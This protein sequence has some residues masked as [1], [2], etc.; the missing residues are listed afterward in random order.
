MLDT[1]APLT[2]LLQTQCSANFKW[3]AHPTAL[4]HW[5][6]FPLFVFKA[7]FSSSA[8]QVS[9]LSSPH[10]RAGEGTSC[11][12]E[13]LPLAIT[14]RATSQ[15]QAGRGSQRKDLASLHWTS[16]F[17]YQRD[18]KHKHTRM[19]TIPCLSETDLFLR[20]GGAAASAATA[21]ANA[22]DKL[23][24]LTSTEHCDHFESPHLISTSNRWSISV[25]MGD[26]PWGQV[27]GMLRCMRKL[28]GSFHAKGFASKE[29]I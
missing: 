28:K 9:Q 21:R 17:L 6:P 16:G 13:P 24:G 29:V 12:I 23:Q 11:E 8:A 22:C 1:T 25:V 7:G 10:Q 26:S 4:V 15:Q 27:R 18:W 3:P 5:K 20:I 2:S 19:Q 14:P